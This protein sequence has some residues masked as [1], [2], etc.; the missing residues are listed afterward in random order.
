MKKLLTLTF[1]T[2]SLLLLALPVYAATEGEPVSKTEA[3]AFYNAEETE[4]TILYG[5]KTVK[6]ENAAIKSGDVTYLP[7]REVLA[8]YGASVSWAVGEAEDKVIV[9]AGKNR[10][11]MVVDLEKC[12]AYGLDN[13][14]YALKHEGNVLYLPVHF[15]TELVNCGLEWNREKCLLTLNDADKKDGVT[16]F[17]PTNGGISY[18]KVLNLPEY[19]KTAAPVVSRSSSA[20]QGREGVYETGTASYYGAK[21]HGRRTSSGEAYNKDA[22]TAAHKTLPFGTI[23]RVTAEWN[24]KSVEVKINDRGPYSHG[25][26]ID[27]STAAARE[28]GMISKGVGTVTLEIVSYPE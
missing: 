14:V 24:Q 1:L 7:L 6:C 8:A 26:V 18:I 17:N 22:Y 5:K 13:K 3:G 2:L 27:I 23:V 15:Y 28:L 16:I 19:V 20:L 25:R 11:Q 12:E 21:F 4:L 10:Y 9:T